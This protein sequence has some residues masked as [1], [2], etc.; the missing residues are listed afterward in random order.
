MYIPKHIRNGIQ[1]EW[2]ICAFCWHLAF[3]TGDGDRDRKRERDR[4]RRRD[5]E[6]DRGQGRQ[7]DDEEGWHGNPGLVGIH[8]PAKQRT[9]SKTVFPQ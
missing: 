7:Q 4:D 1:R 2:R 3:G 6:R 9:F 8:F 5:R